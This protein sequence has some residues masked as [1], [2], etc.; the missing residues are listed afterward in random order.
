MYHQQYRRWSQAR[1]FRLR[2]RGTYSPHRAQ[3]RADKKASRPKHGEAGEQSRLRGE[4]QDRLSDKH[5]P[6]Q[7]GR[8]AGARFPRRSGDAGVPR[9]DL[10][11][12]VCARPRRLKRE[13]TRHLRTGRA[14]RKPAAAADAAVAA[15]QRHGLDQRTAAGGGRPCRAGPLGRRLIVGQGE[16]VG[17]RHPGGTQDRVLMLL[18]LPDDHGASPC[19]KP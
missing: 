7:I 12:L 19:K 13:L 3:L 16:Q 18:H 6:E 17:D 9:N 2:R 11:V 5:S 15:D 1:L 10:P 4:M 8:A 14:L